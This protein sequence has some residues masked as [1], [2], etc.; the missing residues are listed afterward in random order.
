MQE[1]IEASSQLC[2]G[3][4]LSETACRCTKEDED[5]KV[6]EDAPPGR[7]KQVKRLKKVAGIDNPWAVAWASYN[8]HDRKEKKG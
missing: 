2:E 4:G 3:C 6:T 5:V 7:E 1:M 8:K